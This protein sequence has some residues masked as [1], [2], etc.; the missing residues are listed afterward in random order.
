MM[1]GIEKPVS[2]DDENSRKYNT[3]NATFYFK[4]FFM[5]G[6]NDLKYFVLPYS[7]MYFPF[8]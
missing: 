8:H 7:S 3:V 2:P 5:S 4:L 1:I 6:I